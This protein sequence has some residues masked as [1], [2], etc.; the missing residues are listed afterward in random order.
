MCV[1]S[2]FLSRG[3]L[4]NERALR[5]GREKIARQEKRRCPASAF[6]D[7]KI[8]AGAAGLLRFGNDVTEAIQVHGGVPAAFDGGNRF[9]FT[10]VNK[11]APGENTVASYRKQ[12]VAAVA[13]G[14]RAL[15]E[16]VFG[17]FMVKQSRNER[18]IDF[19]LKRSGA[20]AF[21]WFLRK[22]KAK[23]FR[24]INPPTLTALTLLIAESDPKKKEQMV[25]LVTQLLK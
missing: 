19:E 18:A 15:F 10:I 8:F 17:R 16:L 23:K 7:R 25:A 14:H 9:D 24:N 21:I 13:A 22:A 2:N 1:S 6:T 12:Q 4:D 11:R 3:M 20:F 5:I